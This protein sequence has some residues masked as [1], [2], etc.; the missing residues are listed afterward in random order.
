MQRRQAMMITGMALVCGLGGCLRG[1]PDLEAGLWEITSEVEMPGL[2][3]KIPATVYRRCLGAGEFIPK[4]G[5]VEQEICTYSGVSVKGDTV[6]WAVECR[7]PGG[8][9]RTEAEII[10]HGSTFDGT[11]TMG[12]TGV[13]AMDG[14][15]RLSGRRIGDC[16]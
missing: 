6:R 14:S 15:G 12:M 11:M 1:G 5:P 10:Y 16:Q 2:G 13:V 7:S 9:T 4:Q 8:T 3:M